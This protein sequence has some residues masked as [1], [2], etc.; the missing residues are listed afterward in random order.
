MS[1]DPSP[2]THP[3]L[4]AIVGPTASGKSDAAIGLAQMLDGEIINLDSLQ[5]YR[6]LNIGTGKMPLEERC[7]IPHHLLDI[8]EPRESYDAACFQRDAD[9]CIEE[10][11]E[12]GKRPILVGGTGLYLR[13][14]LHGLFDTPSDPAIRA[15]LQ[16]EANQSGLPVLYARLQEVDPTAAGKIGENDSIRIIRALEIFAITGQPFSALAAAHG[17]REQRHEAQILGINPERSLLYERIDRRIDSMFAEG[18]TAEV[19]MLR[20]RGIT[21]EMKPMQCIGYREINQMLD[22]LH[23]PEEAI[24]LIRKHT[25]GYARRQLTWFR[26]EDVT[27][28]TDATT[29]LDQ[30]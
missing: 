4:V 23:P 15:G 28:F 12:R 29:L 20:E 26:K 2:P 19:E 16:E 3:P 13:A 9:R 27:W 21:P 5:I 22:G 1:I 24:R 14:L 10:I 17:H 7:G 18:W 6:Y 8:L 25:R 30:R 11:R